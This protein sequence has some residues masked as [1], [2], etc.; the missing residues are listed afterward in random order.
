M[1]EELPAGAESAAWKG[2]A[3]VR[4]FTIHSVMGTAAIVLAGSM[5]TG[6]CLA[7]GA[8]A[9]ARAP[10]GVASPGATGCTVTGVLMAVAATSAT[11]AWAVGT[12]GAVSVPLILHWNGSKW[13]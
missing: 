2:I 4:A 6:G 13:S 11:N 9:A 8:S 5:V 3:V 10:A 12:K 1:E 7:T